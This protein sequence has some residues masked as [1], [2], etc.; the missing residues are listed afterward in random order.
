ML[1]AVIDLI[2]DISTPVKLGW[3]LWVIW[4][5]AQFEWYRRGRAMPAQRQAPRIEVKKRP[6]VEPRLD[7][8]V[9]VPAHAPAEVSAAVPAD[10]APAAAPSTA[11]SVSKPSRRRRRQAIDAVAGPV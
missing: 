7:T 5:A 6:S 9:E 4:C 8:P 1:A 11:S 10:L 3:M 2:R